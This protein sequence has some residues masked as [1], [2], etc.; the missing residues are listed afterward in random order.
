MKDYL[1]DIIRLWILEFDIDGIR[2]DC[3]DCL[4]FDFMKEMRSVTG[5]IKEDFW[6]MGEVIHGDYSRW[7]NE[8]VL[9][10]TTNYELHK[11]LYSGH[12]DH[13]Y[14][15]IAHTV[16][17]EFEENGGIYRGKTLYSFVD[18]H[19]VDRII[20]KLTNKDHVIPVYT[21]LYTLPG[22]PSLYYGSEWGIEGKKE[23]SNDDPLRPCLDLKKCCEDNKHPD[24][25]KY[26]AALGELRKGNRALAV[27]KYRELLLTNRQYAFAR[28]AE[29][30]AVITAVNNDEN[31]VTLEIPVPI[32]AKSAVDLMSERTLAVE[33]GRIKIDIEACGSV[34][35]KIN[36]G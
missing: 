16:R 10:S 26:I 1:L 29:Q 5:A 7:A 36:Q 12:N 2:L 30:E 14:F 19:D 9:H 20:S 11:G 22:I 18:N 31:Q 32:E 4:D 8:E 25:T 28:I 33:N 27:G 13:N 15:E 23:G 17:R 3:A 21:L 34:I 35:I 24:L 6:L